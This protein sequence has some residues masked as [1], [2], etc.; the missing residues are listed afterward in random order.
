MTEDVTKMW[1]ALSWDQILVYVGGV[2]VL[3]LFF[4]FVGW[5]I[6]D[7][8][9]E[10]EYW[11]FIA[12]KGSDGKNYGD[13]DKLGKLVALVVASLAVSWHSY[14]LKLDALVLGTYLTYAGAIGAWSA[15]LRAKSRP[16]E[17]KPPGDEK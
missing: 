3:C 11:H 12:S 9:N 6:W 5:V 2:V 14:A 8:D 4:A 13:I 1:A 17:S 10:I 15:Y 7:K 16:D